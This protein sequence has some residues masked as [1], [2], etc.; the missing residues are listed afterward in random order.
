MRY[1]LVILFAFAAIAGY[2][3]DGLVINK[4]LS[5]GVSPFLTVATARGINDDKPAY[6]V[7]A[8]FFGS[9][10]IKNQFL[11]GKI[12][13]KSYRYNKGVSTITMED[14]HLL[15]AIK[16]P[17]SQAKGINF[18]GGYS[19]SFIINASDRFSGKSDTIP[20]VYIADQFDNRFSHGFYL[21]FEFQSKDNGSI[22]F[23][24]SFVLNNKITNGYFDAVPN[25]FTVGYNFNFNRKANVPEDVLL[26]RTTL[27]QL[28]SDTLYFINRACLD[29][30]TTNQLDSLLNEHYTYSAYRILSDEEIPAVSK[31]PNVVH[32]AV[33]GKHYGSLGDPESTGLYLL[34]SELNNTKFPYPYHTSNPKNGNGL[35]SCIGG[36]RNAAALIRT[37]NGRLYEKY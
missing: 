5:Y 11:Q 10:R 35:S 6:G 28:T 9:Y 12:G 29:D 8:D 2:G 18:V 33:I 19:P 22:D 4:R 24:Y 32:F 15:L 26:A 1:K 31:Q 23:G 36:L 25:H 17:L 30:F 27:A 3:Q 7:G 37:F 16:Q 21:G 20:T 13:Y 34:D 14:L